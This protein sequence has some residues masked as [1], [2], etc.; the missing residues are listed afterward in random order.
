[1]ESESERAGRKSNLAVGKR[2]SNSDTFWQFFSI[3][4]KTAYLKEVNHIKQ[5][6]ES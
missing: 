6:D 1:V 4:G 5:L 2:N 3:Y